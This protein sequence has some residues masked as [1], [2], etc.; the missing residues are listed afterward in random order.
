[1]VTMRVRLRVD[2]KRM[3][4]SSRVRASVIV[5]IYIKHVYNNVPWRRRGRRAV[6]R[7]VFF[8]ICIAEK[9]VEKARVA[10]FD[11]ANVVP[12]ARVEGPKHKSA[13]P[14]IWEYTVWGGTRPN[15]V[16]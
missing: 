7:R 1:M 6:H 4:T 15:V 12:I 11:D 9:R 8:G 16:E 10:Q 5:T 3:N 13:P 2:V 14:L